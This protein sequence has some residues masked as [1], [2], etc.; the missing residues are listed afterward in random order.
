LD[1]DGDPPTP[2]QVTTIAQK[3]GWS[4]EQTL[5]KILQT[6]TDLR[7]STVQDAVV[8]LE[9]TFVPHKRD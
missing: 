5:E 6:Q 8:F 2:D 1:A 3:Y 7:V 4:E 9:E